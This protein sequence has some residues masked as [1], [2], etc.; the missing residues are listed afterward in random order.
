[1]SMLNNVLFIHGPVT[2][3]THTRQLWWFLKN[4]NDALHCSCFCKFFYIFIYNVMDVL[5]YTL[6]FEALMV[7]FLL[8]W[9]IPNGQIF[10]CIPPR[11]TDLSLVAFSSDL[12]LSPAMNQVRGNILC[13]VFK[14][15]CAKSECFLSEFHP[16]GILFLLF[17]RIHPFRTILCKILCKI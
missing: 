12:L 9:Q 8:N 2:T 11:I 1:M 16:Y 6:Y 15:I 17:I 14:N 7:F 10:R 5:L 3:F 4:W 13:L